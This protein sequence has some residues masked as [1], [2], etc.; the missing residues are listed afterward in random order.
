M[1]AGPDDLVEKIVVLPDGRILLGGYFRQFNGVVRPGIVRL[2]ADGRVDTSFDPGPGPDA[3]IYDI[4]FQSNGKLIVVGDFTSFA[5]QPRSHIARLETNG[6]LDL[7]FD[8]G[9]GVSSWDYPVVIST[10]VQSDDKI[11]IGGFFTSVGISPLSYVARLLKDGAV[12]GSFKLRLPEGSF[13]GVMSVIK[14]PGDSFYIAGQFTTVNNTARTA[15]ARLQPDGSLDG[16]F[17]PNLAAPR[18][19]VSAAVQADGKVVIAGRFSSVDGQSRTNVARLQADGK[20]DATFQPGSG[21]DDQAT[22]V[23]LQPD[24]KAIMGGFFTTYNGVARSRIA[25]L[26]LDGSLD[27]SFDPGT[28]ISGGADPGVLALAVQPDGK[29]LVAGDFTHY[30]GTERK[31][32]L[33]LRGSPPVIPAKPFRLEVGGRRPDGKFELRVAGEAGRLY[34]VEGSANLRD[35][36]TV[37]Q[38]TG[39]AQPVVF[40][41]DTAAG[42]PQRSYRAW[43]P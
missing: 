34:T 16:G 41:D 31:G 4:A 23:V 24:G 32:L 18:T 7:S 13:D 9:P 29:V 35:W 15:I 38:V 10:A 39:G 19:L 25:R 36:G 33:R 27:T 12:D 5:G 28:G 26:N 6:A 20:L 42:L 37:G 17:V 3:G 40:V 14:L 8:A 21:L 30:N 22:A 11:V 2:L 43:T 1:G